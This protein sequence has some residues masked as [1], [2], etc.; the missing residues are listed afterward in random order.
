MTN[1]NQNPIDVSAITIKEREGDTKI[2]R[3]DY[4]GEEHRV[5]VGDRPP[6]SFKELAAANLKASRDTYLWREA[7]W[8]GYQSP[9]H[10]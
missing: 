10:F 7:N 6:E 2:W 4:H 8:Q 5:F 1:I 3:F 9:F